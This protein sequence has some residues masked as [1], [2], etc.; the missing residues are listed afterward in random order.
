[1]DR[2]KKTGRAPPTRTADENVSKTIELKAQIAGHVE[3]IAAFEAE[4]EEISAGLIEALEAVNASEDH[5]YTFGQKWEL[6]MIDP[7]FVVP[8]PA[9]GDKGDWQKT[10]EIWQITK[11]NRYKGLSVAI[12]NLRAR[13]RTA[14]LNLEAMQPDYNRDKVMAARKQAQ[15]DARET[16]RH[17]KLMAK[18]TK[19]TAA[20]KF[21]V[22]QHEKTT[23]D[24][25][26]DARMA[27]QR[28]R[29][30]AS[31]RGDLSPK[32]QELYDIAAM[33]EDEK[34]K[35]VESSNEDGINKKKFKVDNFTD[36]VARQ[37][38]LDDAKNRAIKARRAVVPT[39][40][41]ALAAA[42]AIA[43]ERGMVQSV[44]VPIDTKS[45]AKNPRVPKFTPEENKAKKL[46]AAVKK[47]NIILKR[48]AA[49]RAGVVEAHNIQD[50]VSR[51]TSCSS[52]W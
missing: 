2:V 35:R 32:S 39:K 22:E 24:A 8:N 49:E 23:S 19:Y 13:I 28:Y 38:L 48:Q 30:L 26:N 5:A 21:K 4:Q 40:Q 31:Y 11:F 18:N 41:A 51:G 1:M 52:S 12:T 45:A 10:V 37:Q 15:A 17:E 9:M 42:K 36:P 3:M 27:A 20:A 6:E 46:A 50:K 14:V 44:H 34:R 29:L 25:Y 16:A 43:M 33:E 47:Q 7:G